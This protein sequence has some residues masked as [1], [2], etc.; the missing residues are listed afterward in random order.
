MLTESST[1]EITA[2]FFI[3]LTLLDQALLF[4]VLAVL[5]IV[6]KALRGTFNEDV[7]KPKLGITVLASLLASVYMIVN[8]FKGLSVL[9]VEPGV[10]LGP[11][12]SDETGDII[13]MS[14]VAQ[15]YIGVALLYQTWRG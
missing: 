12:S 7:A 9:V 10:T 1:F 11:L 3:G 2:R 6:M 4:I 5:T 8:G 15:C 13:I 14:W